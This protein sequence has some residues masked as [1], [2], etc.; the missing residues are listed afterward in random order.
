MAQ[1]R[2]VK[3]NGA[4]MFINSRLGG[5][6]D[7]AAGMKAK[8]ADAWFRSLKLLAAIAA[9]FAVIAGEVWVARQFSCGGSNVTNPDAFASERVAAGLRLAGR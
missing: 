3:S 8:R 5:R 1:G 6:C 2:I 7:Y 9:I 4:V